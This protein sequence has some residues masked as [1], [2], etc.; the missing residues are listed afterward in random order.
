MRFGVMSVDNIYFF[1]V[2]FTRKSCARQKIIIFFGIE[3]KNGK[4]RRERFVPQISTGGTGDIIRYAFFTKFPS[5]QQKLSRPS[6][7][8]KTLTNVKYLQVFH[9]Q[10]AHL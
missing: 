4:I 8:T 10:N 6:R 9:A 2:Y 5:Q 3:G 1:S 7:P